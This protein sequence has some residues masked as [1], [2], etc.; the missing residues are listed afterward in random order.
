MEL[1]ICPV[2]W[3]Y[4]MTC[5]SVPTTAKKPVQKFSFVIWTVFPGSLSSVIQVIAIHALLNLGIHG[6]CCYSWIWHNFYGV[7]WL[8]NRRRICS[9]LKRRSLRVRFRR[10]KIVVVCHQMDRSEHR[11]D[12]E[13][14]RG[15]WHWEAKEVAY[16]NGAEIPKVWGTI[17]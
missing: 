5:I 7:Y 3:L 15:T 10:W 8:L 17:I 13:P 1:L 12:K 4:D 11:W 9:P 14:K 16:R 6:C 2:T